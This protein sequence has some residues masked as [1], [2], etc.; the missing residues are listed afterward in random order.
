MLIFNLVTKLVIGRNVPNVDTLFPFTY[1]QM[2]Y[3]TY[4][5]VHLDI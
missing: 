3:T 2:C 4:N 1:L 5:V